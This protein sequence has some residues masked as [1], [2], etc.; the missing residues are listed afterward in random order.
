RRAT[1]S[2]LARVNQIS[3]PAFPAPSPRRLANQLERQQRA[4][5]ELLPAADLDAGDPA[6]I[7]APDSWIGHFVIQERVEAILGHLD[8]ALAA[9]DPGVVIQLVLGLI[10]ELIGLRV[11]LVLDGNGDAG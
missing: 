5:G 3:P 11:L 10:A 6:R 2:A 8:D 1:R 9:A 7:D 4:A